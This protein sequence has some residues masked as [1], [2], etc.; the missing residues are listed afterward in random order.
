MEISRDDLSIQVQDLT[1]AVVELQRRLA[2]LERRVGTSAES[3]EP[4][5]EAM[6]LPIM[7]D[8]AA[9]QQAVMANADSAAPLFGWAFLGLAGAYL[10]RAFTESG[11][12]PGLAGVAAGLAYAV[13]WLWLA[14]RRAEARPLFSI[15]HGVTAALVFAPL[16]YEATVR[17]HWMGPVGASALLVAFAV[18]GLAVGWRGNLTSLAWTCTL[19]VLLTATAVFRETHDALAWAGC[20][21]CV[22][23]TVEFSACRDH[24]LSL[25]WIVALSADLTVLAIT[26]ITSLR[27][28]P[29]WAPAP[30]WVLAAQITLLTI[31]LSSTVDRTL[32]RHLYITGFEMTQA[33]IAFLVAV[34]G[35]LYLADMTRLGV[36]SV[37]VFCLLGAVACYL[38][39]FAL[40]D[41]TGGQLRNFYTYSTFAIV[42]TALACRILLSGAVLTGTW[43]LLAVALLVTGILYERMTLRVHA[44]AYLVLAVT[45]AELVPAATAQLI[46]W[47]TAA[48]APPMAYWFALLG[49]G[50][51]YGGIIVLRERRLGHW[52]DLVEAAVS[53]GLLWWGAAGLVGSW[54]NAGLSTPAPT[55]TALLVLSSIACAWLGR[56]WERKELV[57]LVYPLLVVTGCKLLL[58]DFR[59]GQSLQLFASLIL[60]GGTLIVLPRLLRA[61]RAE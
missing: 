60:F 25:R 6:A 30:A 46:R 56:R 39:A 59:L 41:R 13:W 21:L 33:I 17:F 61:G 37:G 16:L 11:H 34:G 54:I 1:C 51:F 43:A 18:L 42:L 48:A 31:Y 38:V 15:V 5:E 19:A 10:L 36:G 20:V 53:A 27:N 49:A 3:L 23:A 47:N 7:D 8:L 29:E 26:V 9:G 4:R 40:L 55:R 57:W 45:G 28:A 35:A 24:W 50:L 12:I 58:E 52:T 14:G 32:L 2:V 22:A 44:A